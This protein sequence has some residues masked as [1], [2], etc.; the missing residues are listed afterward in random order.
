MNAYEDN[1]EWDGVTRGQTCCHRRPATQQS[2]NQDRTTWEPANVFGIK[3]LAYGT[4]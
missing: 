3:V 2:H 1:T 4:E